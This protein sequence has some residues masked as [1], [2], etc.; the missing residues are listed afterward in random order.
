[1]PDEPRAAF[2]ELT[3]RLLEGLACAALHPAA[4]GVLLLDTS[5]DATWTLAGIYQRLLS[6]TDNALL[7]LTE[8]P[9]NASED[10]LWGQLAPTQLFA[11]S[12]STA[13]TPHIDAL[14]SPPPDATLKLVVLPDLARLGLPALRAATVLVDAPVGHVERNGLS[15]QWAPR[16]RWLAFAQRSDLRFISPHLLDRFP[17]RLSAQQWH[18][19]QRVAWLAAALQMSDQPSQARPPLAPIPGDWVRRV[20]Q[21]RRRHGWISPASDA[22]LDSPMTQARNLRT[23]PPKLLP[24]QPDALDALLE[25]SALN[26]GAGFRRELGLGRLALSCAALEQAAAVAP[27]HVQRAAELMG[28]RMPGPAPMTAKATSPS[29]QAS[30]SHAPAGTSAATTIRLAPK[31][32]GVTAEPVFS[33]EIV[34]RLSTPLTAPVFV[35]DAAVR[36]ETATTLKLVAATEDRRH[37]ERGHIIGA[38]P[39]RTLRDLALLPTLLAAAPYQRIRGRQPAHPLIVLPP[40]LRRYRRALLPRYQLIVVLDQS[41]SLP[42]PW[43]EAL[44]PHIEWAYQRRAPV[45]AIVVGGDTTE[46][47]RAY[48]ALLESRRAEAIQRMLR[49]PA[50]H[51]TP[52][53]HGLYLALQQ[54]EQSQRGVRGGASQVRLVVATDGRANV[55]LLASLQPQANPP[56]YQA[57]EAQADAWVLAATLRGRRLQAFVLDPQP[58]RLA[59]LPAELAAALGANLI[60]VDLK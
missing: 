18:A 5:P 52:L 57:A 21:V 31:P 3:S 4:T 24:M 2:S 7:P 35:E 49:W 53:A 6:P 42:G 26:S 43:V 28:W 14:L 39:T 45:T 60:A 23:S 50:G 54:V 46:P 34:R 59:D 12:N 55:P 36:E 38:L 8:I 11:G 17:I 41:D 48:L 27:A 58:A 10:A 56:P 16:L 32:A 20:R 44:Q 22:P 51:A 13:V 37:E 33:G 1:M 15:L 47:R 25:I 30:P 40:D 19:P 9:A 29:V